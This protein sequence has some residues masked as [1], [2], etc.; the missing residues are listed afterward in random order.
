[1]CTLSLKTRFNVLPENVIRAAYDLYLCPLKKFYGQSVL[2]RNLSRD[3]VC[4]YA[5]LSN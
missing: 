5:V 1:M 2:S 4:L 3:Q